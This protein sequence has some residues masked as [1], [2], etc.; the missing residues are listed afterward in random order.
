MT[1]SASWGPVV[2]WLL[3]VAAV[4]L[5]AAAVAAG[6]ALGRR[7]TAGRSTAAPA[8]PAPSRVALD[9]SDDPRVRALVLGLIGAHD[10]AASNEAV[11]RHV[12]QVL[13]R[14][15]VRPLRADPG[16]EF[17]ADQQEAVATESTADSGGAATVG[18][19][20]RTVRPGWR[21]DSLLYRAT[22]VVVWTA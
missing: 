17:D 1:T 13:R 3:A 19:I 10:L 21:D 6:Y 20:V 16:A 4:A 14:T 12:E 22:E 15:G 11:R 5:I 2:W 7:T 18:T 9:G 8:Q